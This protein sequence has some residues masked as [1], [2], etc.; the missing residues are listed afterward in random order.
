[1]I[2]EPEG[3]PVADQYKSS[4]VT[5]ALRKLACEM[6]LPPEGLVDFNPENDFDGSVDL[7][8]HWKHQPR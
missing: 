7:L 3:F 6:D 5:A 8:R 1:M 2:A 4:G